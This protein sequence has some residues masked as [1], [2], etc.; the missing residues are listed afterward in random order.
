MMSLTINIELAMH[1]SMFLVPGI[2]MPFFRS[3]AL[4]CGTSNVGIVDDRTLVIHFF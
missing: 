3:S 2:K 4:M 1:H